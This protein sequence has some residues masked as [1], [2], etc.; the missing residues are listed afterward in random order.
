M[1]AEDPLLFFIPQDQQVN[2]KEF[3]IQQVVIWF[4]RL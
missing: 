3:Y 1:N 2:P 4:M